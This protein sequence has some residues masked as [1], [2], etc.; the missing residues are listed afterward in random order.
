MP[1]CKSLSKTIA[2]LLMKYAEEVT[3]GPMNTAITKITALVE[4]LERE[5]QFERVLED[6]NHRAEPAT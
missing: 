2:E 3:D 5:K 4:V 6:L 1:E